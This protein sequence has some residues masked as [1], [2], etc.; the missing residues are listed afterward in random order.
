MTRDT[1]VLV[2]EESFEKK[3]RDRLRNDI[4]DLISDKELSSLIKSSFNDMFFKPRIVTR[5]P[6]TYS[7]R[8]EE[9][10]SVFEQTVKEL[11]SDKFETI[12]REELRARK[13]QLVPMIREALTETLAESIFNGLKRMFSNEFVVLEN[14]IVGKLTGVRSS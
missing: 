4:T 10:P 7:S 14:S 8:K 11:L 13:D 3:L 5:D 9:V 2:P 12:L 6:G 1:E